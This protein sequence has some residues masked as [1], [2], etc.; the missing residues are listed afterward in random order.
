MVKDNPLHSITDRNLKIAASKANQGRC[1]NPLEYL[2]DLKWTRRHEDIIRH[3]KIE[4]IG[5]VKQQNH[6]IILPEEAKMLEAIKFYTLTSKF[7]I[8]CLHWDN[9]GVVDGFLDDKNNMYLLNNDYDT[10]KKICKELFNRYQMDEFVRSNQTYTSI[11]SDLLKQL[12]GFI[13]QS[14]YN[15]KTRQMLDDFYSRALQRMSPENPTGDITSIDICKSYPNV[16]LN[17]KCPIPLYSIHD[18]SKPFCC[19]S[20]L[21]NCDESLIDETI[22]ERYGSQIKVEAG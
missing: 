6:I 15:L 20:D 11:A 5:N 16:L 1:H 17:N 4:E 7:Y 10:R 19:R 13:S 18:V 9:K 2:A 14:S 21:L 12:I 22:L 8:E 3:D